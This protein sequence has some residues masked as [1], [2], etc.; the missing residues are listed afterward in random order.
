MFVKSF[1]FL[2]AQCYSFY[3]IQTLELS[4]VKNDDMQG[5]CGPEIHVIILSLFLG[6]EYNWSFQS[7]YGLL[8]S[9]MMYLP[10]YASHGFHN[11][12]SP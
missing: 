9:V 1:C 4:K 10:F 7:E 11:R 5:A 3:L 6:F 2:E 8:K 12:I